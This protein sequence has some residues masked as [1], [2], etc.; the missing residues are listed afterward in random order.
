MQISCKVTAQLISSALFFCYIDSTISLW[1]YSP[2]CVG[3][4]RKPLSQV[5]PRHGSNFNLFFVGLLIGG[6]HN[7]LSHEK[8]CSSI[9]KNKGVDQ[10]HSNCSANQGLFFATKIVQSLFF[11]NLKFQDLSHLL[12]PYSFRVNLIFAN[13]CKFVASQI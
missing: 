7:K 5:F 10:L 1:L 6:Y 11:L 9:L 3:P 4:G 8:T 12:W 13:I 2:V